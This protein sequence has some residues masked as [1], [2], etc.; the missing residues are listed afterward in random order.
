MTTT[1]TTPEPVTTPTSPAPARAGNRWRTVDIVV[2]IGSDGTA[3][4]TFALD[5]SGGS[6]F[7][8]IAMTYTISGGEITFN[9]TATFTGGTGKFRVIKGTVTAYHH[10]TLDGQSGTVKLDGSARY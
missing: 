10:H 7:G 3:T 6:A 2:T 8:T 1:D 5:A 4:G 9:G